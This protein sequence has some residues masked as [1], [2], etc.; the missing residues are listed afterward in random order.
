MEAAVSLRKWFNRRD[1]LHP[2]HCS[3]GHIAVEIW[4]LGTEKLS[5]PLKTELLSQ[6]ELARAARY[7]LPA[8]RRQFLLGRILGRQVIASKLGIDPGR[9]QWPTTG[10]P[11]LR[12]EGSPLPLSVS[13]THSGSYFGIA[14][15]E[16]YF[17]SETATP[18]SNESNTLTA[19]VGFD[20]EEVASP[21]HV[22]ALSSV[23]L[24]QR[25]RIWLADL[26][27]AQHV[28]AVR[29]LWT[30]KEAILKSL[31]QDTLPDLPDLDL[32]DFVS[33]N[34]PPFSRSL[35]IPC[36][37]P[38]M[39]S[40]IVAT[41]PAT[42]HEMNWNFSDDETVDATLAGM[43]AIRLPNHLDQT[44]LSCSLTSRE[45]QTSGM[46]SLYPVSELDCA[47]LQL[48]FRLAN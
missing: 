37:G 15:S 35:N 38:I 47:S 24:T 4:L 9:I 44:S 40:P 17:R 18:S 42:S 8:K 2:P 21:I 29:R 28:A 39:L 41:S 46:R 19:T 14:L 16:R 7:R 31:E 23:A 43:I 27:V 26:P 36:V 5:G 12:C 1:Q 22:S 30:A 32:T 10:A 3:A 11:L 6:E 20:F 25:E 34:E 33:G 13:L 45:T 48:N